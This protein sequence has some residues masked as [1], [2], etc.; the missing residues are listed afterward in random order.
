MM[1]KDGSFL[2][3]RLSALQIDPRLLDLPE[4]HP[5]F[6]PV[7]IYR[8]FVSAHLANITGI[9]RNTIYTALQWTQSLERG[10]LILAVPRLR[11]KLGT[12]SELAKRWAEEVSKSAE[13]Q[14]NE[15]VSDSFG[16]L[17]C[18]IILVP[19]KQSCAASSRQCG[20]FIICILASLAIFPCTFQHFPTG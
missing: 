17:D 20:K 8:C 4:S 2:G 6:N 18:W 13:T 5:E 10:D 16:S 15:A 14:I 12:P 3:E 1:A 11:V 9:D 7:D 19:T